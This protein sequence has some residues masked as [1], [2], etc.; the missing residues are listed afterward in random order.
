MSVIAHGVDITACLRIERIW[1][2]HGEHFLQRIYTPAE[3]EYCLSCKTPAERLAGRFA[4]KEAV[5]KAL[6]TGWR[7]GM[8]WT[9]VETLADPLGRPLVT[10]HGQ[11]AELAAALGIGTILISIS[12]TPEYAI[13]S[14][15]ALAAGA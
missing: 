8:R 14:A 10:L 6:G 7:G 5:M 1:Q 2:E 12:H 3:R 15:L 11:T 13:A 9:D 4:A